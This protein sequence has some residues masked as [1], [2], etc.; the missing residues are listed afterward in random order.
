MWKLPRGAVWVG[1]DT[2]QLPSDMCDPAPYRLIRFTETNIYALIG[3]AGEIRTC[4][5]GWAEFIED[6]LYADDLS[7]TL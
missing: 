7:D 2:V 4:P 1:T 6:E 5:Q 3:K